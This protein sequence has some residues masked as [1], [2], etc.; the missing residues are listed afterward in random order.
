ML[1]VLILINI[2]APPIAKS[3]VEKH[4]KEIV[5]RQINVDKVR[6][7][8]FRGKVSLM[9]VQALEANDKDNFVSFNQ[10][11]VNMSVWR[12][13]AKEVRLTEITLVQPVVS[14]WQEGKTFNFTDIIKRFTKKDKKKKD[15]NKRSWAIDLRN[16]TLDRGSVVY[17]DLQRDSKFDIRDLS[18]EVPRLYFS[19]ERRSDIGLNLKFADGGD[20]AVKLLYGLKDNNYDLTIALKDFS[21]AMAK[22]YL[23]EFLNIEDF[24]GKLTADLKV[25]GCLEHILD[26][27]AKGTVALNNLTVNTSDQQELA[28]IGQVKVNV[29][30][31][32]TRNKKFYFNEVDVSG[33]NFVYETNGSSNTMSR[34]LVKRDTLKKKPA[35]ETVSQDTMQ[36]RP[37]DLRIG[38]V[39]LTQSSVTYVDRTM[40]ETFSLPITGITISA[41]EMSL[42]APFDVRLKAIVGEGGQLMGSWRGSLA[43]MSNQNFKVL[44]QNVKMKDFSPFS[45]HYLAYPLTGGLLSFS[46]KDVIKNNYIDSENKVDIYKCTVGNKMTDL[47]PEYNIPLKAAVYIL[48]DRK[49]K[50]AIDLPVSGDISSPNFSFKKIIFKTLINFLV[51]VV[52]SPIDMIIKACGGSEDT[53]ADVTYVLTDKSLSS[54]TYA[55]LNSIIEV[56]KAKPEMILTLQQSVNMD[57]ARE[58]F[59]RQLSTTDSVAIAEAIQRNVDHHDMMLKNYF[60]TQGIDASNVEMLP[61]E[62]KKTPKGKSILSFGVKLP[63]SM[64]DEIEE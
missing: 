57:E 55:R 26:I 36:S 51:K 38:K 1:L 3:Y 37:A 7:N 60:A 24:N 39:A 8:I 28:G 15:P 35:K 30:E 44:I 45:V 11:V 5:G 52:A 31:L 6:L 21:V 46:T 53:F 59:A 13:L 43:D 56:M 63:P 25:V 41:D 64:M 61:V 16:I 49:D 54:E 58:Q 10:L 18:L 50:I 14:I 22:P 34:L 19:G 12:L 20:L 33:L 32:D 47:K 62:D 9:G 27:V 48:S 17:R 23:K 2:I 4:S 42:N 29:E 40:K